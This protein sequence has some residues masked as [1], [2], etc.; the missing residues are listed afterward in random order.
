LGGLAWFSRL[1]PAFFFFFLSS[2][3]IF[4]FVL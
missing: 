3:A 2:P 4:K 1:F